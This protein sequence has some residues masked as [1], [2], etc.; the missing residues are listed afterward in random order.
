MNQIFSIF[1]G[2]L[3]P[4][5][6]ASTVKSVPNFFFFI[7]SGLYLCAFGIYVIVVRPEKVVS[8]KI[9]EEN[10]GYVD[11]DIGVEEQ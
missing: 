9:V 8:M 2:I 3:F 11:E 7:V 4:I 1:S 5:V 10:E 6:W